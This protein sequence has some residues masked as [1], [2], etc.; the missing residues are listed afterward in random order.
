MTLPKQ[1]LYDE[2]AKV[3]YF[4][5]AMLSYFVHPNDLNSGEADSARSLARSEQNRLTHVLHSLLFTD[6]TVTSEATLN[7]MV[8]IPSP[9]QSP[10]YI[11]YDDGKLLGSA[12][13]LS[14]VANHYRPTSF[15][16]RQPV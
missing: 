4:T 9:D 10:L 6:F 11:R 7:F 12:F 14:F 1:P 8:Y 16:F 15:S 13:F 3:Y 2:Q 5:P